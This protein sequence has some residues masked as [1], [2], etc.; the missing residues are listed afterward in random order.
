MELLEHE[1]PL[2]SVNKR[3]ARVEGSSLLNFIKSANPVNADGEMWRPGMHV[4]K[5]SGKS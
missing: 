3:G 4:S 2:C 1:H 5:T